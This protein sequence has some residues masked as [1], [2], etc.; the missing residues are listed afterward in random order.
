MEIIVKAVTTIES[1]AKKR[2]EAQSDCDHI[3]CKLC[4]Y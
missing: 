4:Q 2:Q 1:Y 3:K